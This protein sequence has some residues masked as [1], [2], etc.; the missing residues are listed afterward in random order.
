M[1]IYIIREVCAPEFQLCHGFLSI[2]LMLSNAQKKLEF[3]K[4]K[5]PYTYQNL[6]INQGYLRK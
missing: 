1:K 6:E 3:L 2:H 4:K 5:D